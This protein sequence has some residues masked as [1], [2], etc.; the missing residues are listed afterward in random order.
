MEDENKNKSGNGNKTSPEK[1]RGDEWSLG[2][3]WKASDDKDAGPVLGSSDSKVDPVFKLP[4]N[5][6]TSGSVFIKVAFLLFG[7]VLITAYMLHI[8]TER[9][10]LSLVKN[11]KIETAENNS[12][13]QPLVREPDYPI[14]PQFS[15]SQ[16]ESSVEKS[17]FVQ[18]SSKIV[19]S[20]NMLLSSS[21]QR[22][23]SLAVSSQENSSGDSSLESYSSAIAYSS[24]KQTVVVSS[25][26][27]AVSSRPKSNAVSS[28]Q[29]LPDF[30]NV[31]IKG[32]V[33]LLDETGAVVDVT[34][35]LDKD[36]FSGLTWEAAL[37]TRDN[38]TDNRF[39]EY[40]GSQT[41]LGLLNDDSL[42]VI[43]SFVMDSAKYK[44]DGLQAVDVRGRF[45][46]LDPDK[47]KTGNYSLVLSVNNT[48]ISSTKL[49]IGG[50]ALAF[51]EASA[52]AKTTADKPKQVGE[53]IDVSDINKGL[54]TN[55]STDTNTVQSPGEN[56]KP[57]LQEDTIQPMDNSSAF[58]NSSAVARSAKV[59]AM[60]EEQVQNIL[61]PTDK[62]TAPV[63]I[64]VEPGNTIQP[65][66][67]VALPAVPAEYYSGT[68]NLVN[69]YGGKI[70]RSIVLTINFNADNTIQGAAIVSGV[71]TMTVKG[72]VYERGL[73]MVLTGSGDAI[74]LTGVKRDLTIRG[75]FASGSLKESGSFEV[76]R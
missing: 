38:I 57:T 8:N 10:K 20:G 28:V 56:I 61:P 9:Q 24:S 42:Q 46:N 60:A 18:A 52:F 51:A 34:R 3:D 68:A 30:S 55:T 13:T 75:R 4:T 35:S 49:T 32:S 15:S 14:L 48:V 40:I 17:S 58:A 23:S 2:E 37:T 7:A 67:E 72:Q 12:V 53:D 76:S 11:I 29:P 59:E 69:N 65:V 54:D 64:P 47:L 62:A 25:S 33:Q 50:H 36:K 74:Q 70:Q 31:V 71:G 44:G 63:A 73:E 6:N 66:Q 26:P 39:A 21:V 5:K 16:Q 19:V 22:S 43:D 41:V 27:K 45:L 1:R